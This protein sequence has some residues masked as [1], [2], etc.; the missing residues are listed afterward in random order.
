MSKKVV[1]VK[2]VNDMKN[3]KEFLNIR[4]KFE[5]FVRYVE[6]NNVQIPKAF[7]D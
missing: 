4:V 6:K 7:R 3:N 5:D 1:Y 2:N